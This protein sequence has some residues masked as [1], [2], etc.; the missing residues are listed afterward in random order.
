MSDDLENYELVSMTHDGVKMWAHT[1]GS[2]DPSELADPLESD[3]VRLRREIQRR[4]L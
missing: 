2:L 1:E 3:T 4:N